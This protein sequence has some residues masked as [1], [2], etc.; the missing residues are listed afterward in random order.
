MSKSIKE[1]EFKVKL[2]CSLEK[3]FLDEEPKEDISLSKLTALKGETVSFQVAYTCDVENGYFM[4]AKIK[5]PIADKVRLRQVVNMP[6]QFPAHIAI[7]DNYLRTNVGLYP[8]LLRDLEDDRVQMIAGK[9]HSLWVDIEISQDASIGKI[10][11]TVE[12]YEYKEN[13]K[14]AEVTQEITIYDVV[15]P[16]QKLI[17]TEWFHSDCVAQA[18]NVEVFSESHWNIL[19][20]FI[21]TAVKRGCNMILTP[22]FTPPLDTAKGH[23]RTT[24]QLVDINFENDIYSFDFSNLKRWVDMCK[25]IGMIYF[26][27]SHL[28]SQWGA[29]NAPKIM[30]T[31]QGEYKQLF[32]WHTIA[33][34]KEYVTFLNIYLPELIKKLKEW[35]IDKNTYFHLSDEP[36]MDHLESY[37]AAKNIVKD[38]LKDYV[39]MDA[40]SHYDFYEKGLVEKPVSANDSIHDFLDHNVENMW[41]YYCT[42]QNINVSNRFFSMPSQ[43][44]RIYAVQLFKYDIE[45]ILH[46]GYNFYN[47]MHSI[48]QVNPYVDTCSGGFFPGGDPFLVYPK[49]DGTPEESIRIMVLDEAMNDLRAFQLLASKVGKERVLEI[50]ENGINEPITFY[51]Y[52]TSKN[53]LICLRNTINKMLSEI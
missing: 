10:P 2:L 30:A 14:K 5:S 41:S 36:N 15:L 12:F 31:V 44:N 9:W 1:A 7:D 6:C 50:I 20:K 28:F 40:L 49:S 4:R 45:G 53:W 38:V 34:S 22:Q 43:R 19:E 51:K 3:V 32:G 27:M 23:E 48:H 29:T 11:I 25:K 8:D 39:I 46:W 17:H 33:T 24:V 37:T 42:A 16:K 52:P 13:I 26:E 18:Y 21:S 47:S 35:G